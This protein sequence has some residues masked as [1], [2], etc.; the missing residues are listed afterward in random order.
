MNA[1]NVKPCKHVNLEIR[2]GYINIFSP[3]MGH[4]Q[5]QSLPTTPKIRVV[6]ETSKI[7]PAHDFRTTLDK[8][9]RLNAMTQYD[10]NT[11]LVCKRVFA[12]F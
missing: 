7:Q 1:E 5:K 9:G 2:L 4:A 3:E 12:S 11:I 6:Q 8:P 10:W